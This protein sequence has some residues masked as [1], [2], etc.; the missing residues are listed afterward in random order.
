M[1]ITFCGCKKILDSYS[2]K[3]LFDVSKDSAYAYIGGL[4]TNRVI[5]PKG[6]EKLGIKL[7][8]MCEIITK[9]D[10][11]LVKAY[12]NEYYIYTYRGKLNDV[13]NSLITLCCP[14]EALF[15]PGCLRAFISLDTDLSTEEL[16]NHYKNS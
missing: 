13:K 8:H 16:L 14:K 6:H 9:D 1:I 10:V 11:D 4:R 3:K 2:N 5:Y 12:K 7:N 15:K